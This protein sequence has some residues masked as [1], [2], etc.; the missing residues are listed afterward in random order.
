VRRECLRFQT[1]YLERPSLTP[2]DIEQLIRERVEVRKA[3]NFAR[4]D[5]IRNELLKS[6]VTLLD[7]A[8]GGT[9]WQFAVTAK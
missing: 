8:T 4:S 6:G 2:E 5:E 1:A 3:K 7:A 9:T